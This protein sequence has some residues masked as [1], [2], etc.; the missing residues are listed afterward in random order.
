[1]AM[2]AQDIVIYVGGMNDM[3]SL[4]KCNLCNAYFF[5]DKDWVNRK[6]RHEEWHS[7][8]LIQ[9]RNTTQGI[10]EWVEYADL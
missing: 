9:K 2:I 3:T 8:A 5:I 1:M 6:P 4:I 7:K 10:V